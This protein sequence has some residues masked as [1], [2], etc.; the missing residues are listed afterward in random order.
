ME[1]Q[2]GRTFTLSQKMDIIAVLA[3][4][5]ALTVM[6]FLRRKLGYRF[7]DM[8]KIQVTVLLL[9]GL[10]AFSA[11]ANPR[12][13]AAFFLFSLAVLAFAYVGR[14]LRWRDIKNGIAWHTYSR[15]VSWINYIIPLRE[16]TV[17]RFL[18]PLIVAVIGLVLS[19]VFS[20]FGYF[21]VFSAACLFIFEAWD[22]DKAVNRMLDVLDSQVES[23]VV[24]ANVEYFEQ[25]GQAN[26]RPV[27][28]TAGIPTGVA[29]DLAAAI[30]RRQARPSQLASPALPYSAGQPVQPASGGYTAQSYPL[31][32]QQG[33]S[34]N[35]PY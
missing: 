20:W 34:N 33:S 25:G 30:A 35:L 7:I 13:G 12:A 31:Q 8:M 23:E 21:L 22:Y 4:F 26:E 3:S 6:V 16:T 1:E 2:Q 27:E 32:G 11:V 17:K 18:D 24:S 9:W 14:W 28:Q 29:P 10:S 19:F 5:P 15:G